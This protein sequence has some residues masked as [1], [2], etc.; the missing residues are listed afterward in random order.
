MASTALTRRILDEHRRSII[1]LVLLLV[2]NALAYALLVYPLSQRVANVTQRTAAAEQALTAARRDYAQASGTLTGK[3]RA[4]TE[5]ATFYSSVLPANQDE[6]RRQTHLRLAQLAREAHLRYGHVTNEIEPLRGSS[7]TRLKIQMELSGTYADMRAFVHELE[8]S[9]EFVVI[10]NVELAS[11]PQA[12][13]TLTVKLAL[14]TYYREVDP[15][16]S[17]G[18]PQRLA[19]P[20]Q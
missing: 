12:A 13:N 9:P 10:D 2:V 20:A 6:A 16:G 18:G 1:P 8:T 3:S 7:L 4:A 5:L 17:P 11:E 14:S 19:P 15:S